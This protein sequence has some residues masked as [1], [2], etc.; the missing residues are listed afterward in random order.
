M[1][2]NSPNK[3]DNDS[4]NRG[5]ESPQPAQQP[6]SDAIVLITGDIERTRATGVAVTPNECR[7]GFAEDDQLQPNASA[8]EVGDNIQSDKQ[9]L[10][11][12]LMLTYLIQKWN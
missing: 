10:L 8:A 11:H 6:N 3:E 1:E 5:T 4:D 12:K 9:V 7:D 2:R